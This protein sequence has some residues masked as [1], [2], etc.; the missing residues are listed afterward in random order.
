MVQILSATQNLRR[1]QAASNQVHLPLIKHSA[2]IHTSAPASSL[3]DNNV[4]TLLLSQRLFVPFVLPIKKT[5]PSVVGI[6]HAVNV[7]PTLTYAPFAGA[8]SKLG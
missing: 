1:N 2:S 4:C 5:W 6:R 7:D 3:A 8:P